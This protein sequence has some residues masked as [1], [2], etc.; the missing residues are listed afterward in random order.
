MARQEKTLEQVL[1][2]LSD[3]NIGFEDLRNLLIGL[4]FR[5]R[6]SG[7]HYIFRRTASKK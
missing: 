2:G 7:S 1:G 4:G 6:T 3:A 5:E